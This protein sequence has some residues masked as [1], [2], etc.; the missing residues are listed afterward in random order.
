MKV[1]ENRKTVYQK[2]SK[3]QFF[4]QTDNYDENI[5]FNKNIL[6][7]KTAKGKVRIIETLFTTL[8]TQH[9]IAS[10]AQDN[11]A[12]EK[13]IYDICIIACFDASVKCTAYRGYIYITYTLNKY[14]QKQTIGSNTS[15]GFPYYGEVYMMLELYKKLRDLQYKHNDREIVVH[16]NNKCLSIIMNKQKL[17]YVDISQDALNII[18]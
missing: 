10:I 9:T 14:N 8:R 2:H 4:W 12:L 17:Q 7:T 11:I 3:Y 6:V 1:D 16:T 5:K 15:V 13:Q 18:K